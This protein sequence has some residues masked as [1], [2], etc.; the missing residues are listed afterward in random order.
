MGLD[1]GVEKAGFS[2]RVCVEKDPVAVS[3]IRANTTIPVI[4]RDITLVSSDEI[5]AAAG[6]RRE[7]VEM[8]VGGPPCQAFSTAGAQRGLADF[9]GNVIIQYLRVVSEIHPPYFVLENVRG[10]LSASLRAVPEGY[11]E[12]SSIADRKGS[13]LEFL[14]NEF[15]RAGYSVS[16]AL[17]NS[18]KE[19]D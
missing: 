16:Y 2:V 12:Y 18:G 4:S 15:E 6:L 13:V 1:L 9:R 19:K 7:E 17:L 5:L 11:G 8:V 10:L 14:V 3:T